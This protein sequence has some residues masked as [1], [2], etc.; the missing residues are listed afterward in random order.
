L[1]YS[2]QAAGCGTVSDILRTAPIAGQKNGV[3]MTDWRW[4]R[5]AFLVR[6]R[7]GIGGVLL[8]S[9]APETLHAAHLFARE[10]AE[11]SEAFRLLTAEEAADVGAFAMQV[12]PT[13]ETPG[14]AEANVVHFIDRVL[15]DFEP[16]AQPGFRRAIAELNQVSQTV[17]G[18]SVRFAALA[19]EQQMQVMGALEKLPNTARPDMLGSF[20]GIGSNSFD[21]LRSLV[22]AGFLSDPDLGGNKGGVGWKVIGFDGMPVHEPPF[23]YYDAELLSGPEKKL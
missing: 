19:P 1:Q 13:D 20:Y 4:S 17:S 23:G 18:Q 3:G 2:N 14:A 10:A 5:R 6:S 15:V 7:I 21:V 8:A 11:K 16:G 12:V 22:L 9:I